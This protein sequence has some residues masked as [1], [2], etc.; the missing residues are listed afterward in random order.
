MYYSEKAL[1]I[2]VGHV[3]TSKILKRVLESTGYSR[4]GS[5]QYREGSKGGGR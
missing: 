3:P 4:L 1:P 5:F 2:K